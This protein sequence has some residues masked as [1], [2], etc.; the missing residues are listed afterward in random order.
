[1]LFITFENLKR[2]PVTTITQIATFM[3]YS[4][5][6][7]EVIKDIAEKTTFDKMRENDTVNYSWKSSRWAAQ[8]TPFMRQEQLVIGR[9]SF[10]LMILNA[11]IKFIMPVLVELD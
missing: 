4:H 11:W 8:A 10:L 9:T 1:M 7:Q 5:L 2:D 3:G 6:S